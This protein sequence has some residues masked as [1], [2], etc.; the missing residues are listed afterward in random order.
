MAGKL[1]S[2]KWPVL[3]SMLYLIKA[4]HLYFWLLI[5]R[6]FYELWW[7]M[8]LSNDWFVCFRSSSLNCQMDR[9]LITG[10][11]KILNLQKSWENLFITC[12]NLVLMSPVYM[13]E[14]RCDWHVCFASLCSFVK[15]YFAN[16]S[17][18][19]KVFIFY[20]EY[21]R[22][23]I[24]KSWPNWGFLTLTFQMTLTFIKLHTKKEW[25]KSS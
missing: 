13:A 25:V 20:F 9:K 6:I 24:L 11:I 14:L 3:I 10:W 19:K 23:I 15:N 22:D 2:R 8:I 12:F 21:V 1:K 17:F 5:N 18:S 7:Y 4:C 16:S